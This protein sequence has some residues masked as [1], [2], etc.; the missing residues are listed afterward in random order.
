M[1]M[2]HLGWWTEAMRLVRVSFL[3]QRGRFCQ[4][5]ADQVAG[6]HAVQIL[7]Y[8][9]AYTEHF[10]F[11]EH[12]IFRTEVISILPSLNNVCT[13]ITKVGSISSA[14]PLIHHCIIDLHRSI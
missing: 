11:R 5:A 14:L 13:V 12:I 9:K 6:A 4:M 7:E 1:C 8:L 2:I 3:P 10:G